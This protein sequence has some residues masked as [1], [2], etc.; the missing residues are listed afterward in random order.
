MKHRLFTTIF[1][2]ILSQGA[3]AQAPWLKQV[4]DTLQKELVSQIDS[5]AHEM[6][7]DHYDSSIQIS[8]LDHRLN[9]QPCKH[10]L[11]I[12][13]PSP[14][15]LGRAHIKVQCKD[16]KPWALNVP[17]SLNLETMVVTTN[18]PIPRGI[19]LKGHHLDYKSRNLAELRNG[20]FLKKELVIGKQSKRALSGQ[21]ILTE[22]L[23]LP[24]LMVR[25]GDRVMIM[26][27]KGSM[28]VKMPGEALNNGREG[29][30]IR[31]KNV[32]S[33][34]IVKGKVVAPGLVLVN[35]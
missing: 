1:A 17:V 21:T 18:Q 6:N 5:M 8:Y 15:A 29:R 13:P 32:R 3:F 23:I 33:Q 24:A 34:R 10:P 26:A 25:K 12:D 7:L 30:Q 19:T 20:Y 22:H 16:K 11:Q 4:T 14:L 35:F 2:L 27:E 28:N 9:F 31:V